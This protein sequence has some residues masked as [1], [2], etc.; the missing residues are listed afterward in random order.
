MFVKVYLG[1]IHVAQLLA[2]TKV[3]SFSVLWVVSLQH[4]G[5]CFMLG[6]AA[7]RLCRCNPVRCMAVQVHGCAV[8]V[9]GLCRGMAVHGSGCAWLCRCMAVAVHGRCMAVQVHGSGCAW[10]CRCMAVAVHGRCMAVQWPCRGMAVHG[11]G[12]AWLCRCM[13]V[14]WPCRGMAM[15]EHAFAG[16][17]LSSRPYIN[18]VPCIRWTEWTTCFPDRTLIIVS[19]CTCRCCAALNCSKAHPKWFLL[20]HTLGWLNQQSSKPRPKWCL[21]LDTLGWLNQESSKPYPKWCLLLHTLGWL[22]QE[23]SKPL[24]Q[25]TF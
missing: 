9:Q 4:F 8:A 20:L 19:C 12:C 7:A 17:T 23:S 1:R 13:A 14:Q 22:N 15:Q 2:S 6:W 11:S 16:A 25:V 10:L 5:S 18:S 24:F 3:A 21:L